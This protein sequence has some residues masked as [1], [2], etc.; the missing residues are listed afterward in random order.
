MNIKLDKTRRYI[1]LFALSVSAFPGFAANTASS[2][3]DLSGFSINYTNGSGTLIFSEYSENVFLDTVVGGKSLG[4]LSNTNGISLNDIFGTASSI[5]ND[6]SIQSTVSVFS[7]APNINITSASSNSIYFGTIRLSGNGIAQISVPYSMQTFVGALGANESAY[8][9]AGLSAVGP[10]YV[11]VNGR[12]QVAGSWSDYSYSNGNPNRSGTLQLLITNSTG[13]DENI[14][15][16]VSAVSFVG[17]Q[18]VAAVPEPETYAMLLAG[19]GLIGVVK[20][21]KVKKS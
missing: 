15:F 6:A 13:I 1:T 9:S 18:S 21:R 12:P 8:S 20:R 3:V 7:A 10:T 19:L 11:D 4:A 5:S 17:T 2:F 14:D 16:R